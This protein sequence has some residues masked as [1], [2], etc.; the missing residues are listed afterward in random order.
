M[1]RFLG[2]AMMVALAWISAN[3]LRAAHREPPSDD[4][5][6]SARRTVSATTAVYRHAPG[7]QTAAVAVDWSGYRGIRR[8][9]VYAWAPYAPLPAYSAAYYYHR[10]WYVGAYATPY[11]LWNYPAAYGFGYRSYGWGY[12]GG[13]PA[14]GAYGNWANGR[15]GCLVMLGMTEPVGDVARAAADSSLTNPPSTNSS[16]AAAGQDEY[17]GC[18]YW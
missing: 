3:S 9:P 1:K 7:E 13:W 2:C 12:A 11:P 17:S 15:P 18:Y 6:E 5:A 16:P 14:W 10:P 4:G 8:Y